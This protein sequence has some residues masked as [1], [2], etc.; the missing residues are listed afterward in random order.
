MGL[1]R[2]EMNRSNRADYAHVRGMVDGQEY[3]VPLLRVVADTRPGQQTPESDNHHSLRRAD[4]PG[5]DMHRSSC[6]LTLE[7]RPT[8]WPHLG[9]DDAIKLA[10]GLLRQNSNRLAFSITEIELRNLLREAF[11]L[12][13]LRPLKSRNP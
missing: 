4:I 12:L 6:G 13:D 5:P 2:K 10:M 1:N 8:K 11:R 3:K 7:G 9:R